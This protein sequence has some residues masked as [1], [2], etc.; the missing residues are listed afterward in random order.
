MVIVFAS[1][2]ELGVVVDIAWWGKCK[3]I[4]SGDTAGGVG[5]CSRPEGLIP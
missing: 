5:S 3:R 2:K 1:C 4:F